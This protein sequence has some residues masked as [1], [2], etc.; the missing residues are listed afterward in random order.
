M[1]GQ[2]SSPRAGPIDWPLYCR[3]SLTLGD[4]AAG[5]GVCTLWTPR[6]RIAAGLTPGSF[7]VVGN[8]YSREGINLLLRNVLANPRVT[9]LVACGEEGARPQNEER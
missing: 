8:L 6:E 3:E 4:P 1:A 7:A 2:A 5:V 9:H